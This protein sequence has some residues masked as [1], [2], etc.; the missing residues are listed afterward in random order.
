M[1]FGA[2]LREYSPGEDGWIWA[3]DSASNVSKKSPS[4][5]VHIFSQLS[6]RRAAI[7]PRSPNT[8]SRIE[9]AGQEICLHNVAGIHALQETKDE[10]TVNVLGRSLIAHIS[11]G[12]R[13]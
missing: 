2:E 3:D 8:H 5:S 10:Q 4:L 12:Q 7:T 9:Q 1:K 11:A 6:L 13:S